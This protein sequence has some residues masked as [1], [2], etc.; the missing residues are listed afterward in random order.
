M[1]PPPVR[2]MVEIAGAHSHGLCRPQLQI[3]KTI[4]RPV[5]ALA[6]AIAALIS[7]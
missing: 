1:M 6:R 3:D 4:G 7:S 2:H 5:R